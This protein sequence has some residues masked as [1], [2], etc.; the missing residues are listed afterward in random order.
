MITPELENSLAM[1][2]EMTASAKRLAAVVDKTGRIAT[3]SPEVRKAFEGS[4]EF[5]DKL[6]PELA[7]ASREVAK[8]RLA[9]QK[10]LKGPRWGFRA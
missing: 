9:V 10:A 2:R 6:A 4:R 3:A 8:A 5:L 1:L 7:S